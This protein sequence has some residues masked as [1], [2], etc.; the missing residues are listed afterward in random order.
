M[1][2]LYLGYKSLFI[3]DNVISYLIYEKNTLQVTDIN[4]RL[5]E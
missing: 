3:F 4:N 2:A 5:G 1:E